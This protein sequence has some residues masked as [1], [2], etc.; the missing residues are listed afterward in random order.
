MGRPEAVAGG[1][2]L[3]GLQRAFQ[4]A[5]ARTLVAS[6]WQVPDGATCQPMKRF[7][8]NLGARQMPRL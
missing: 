6:L 3:M 4:L 2:G 8:E 1:E 5:G 7:C